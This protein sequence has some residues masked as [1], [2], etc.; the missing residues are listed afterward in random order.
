MSFELSIFT[1]ETMTLNEYQ[2][3]KIERWNLNLDLSACLLLPTVLSLRMHM[4][5]LASFYPVCLCPGWV[6]GGVHC[7]SHYALIMYK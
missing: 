1:D 3:G 5:G 6:R 4:L 2:E 7:N